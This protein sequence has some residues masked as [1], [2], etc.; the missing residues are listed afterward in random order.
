MKE[1]RE[2]TS[3]L[4]IW[5]N[6]QRK[7]YGIIYTENERKGNRDLKEEGKRSVCKGF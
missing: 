1:G 3:F 7:Q 5:N 6:D 2:G 4:L